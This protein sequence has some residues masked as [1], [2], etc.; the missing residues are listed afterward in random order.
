[1]TLETKS[2][3]ALEPCSIEKDQIFDFKLAEYDEKCEDVVKKGNL[4]SRGNPVP[5]KIVVDFYIDK[6][7]N[8]GNL[9]KILKNQSGD[10]GQEKDEARQSGSGDCP[11]I[12]SGD[13]KSLVYPIGE[14]SNY[15]S[16]HNDHSMVSDDYVHVDC[17]ENPHLKIKRNFRNNDLYL[18]SFLYTCFA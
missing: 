13:C 6:L 12:K 3:V 2:K 10:S 15:S 16:E 14:N 17:N 5:Q 11:D 9:Q 8:N 7:L 1:M 4:I 18:C